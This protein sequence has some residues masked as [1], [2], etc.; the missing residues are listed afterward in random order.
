MESVRVGVT[1]FGEL[2][3]R[4]ARLAAVGVGS[5]G[6]GELFAKRLV[7]AIPCLLLAWALVARCGIGPRRG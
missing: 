1:F 7:V 3:G 5:L 4:W 2:A 6:L